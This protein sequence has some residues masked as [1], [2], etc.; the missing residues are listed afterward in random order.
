MVNHYEVLDLPGSGILAQETVEKA[1]VKKASAYASQS[2]ASMHYEERAHL[3]QLLSAFEV[4]G[5]G[6]DA[7]TM[8]LHYVSTGSI[9]GYVPVDDS[10]PYASTV[11]VANK[12]HLTNVKVDDSNVNDM[13]RLALTFQCYHM[14]G[15]TMKVD[16][17]EE[18][19]STQFQEFHNDT[20][21]LI[22]DSEKRALIAA[23]YK[24][25]NATLERAFWEQ[26][27][28]N[29][30]CAHRILTTNRAQYDKCLQRG[31]LQVS[32]PHF[33]PPWADM[34]T[35]LSTRDTLLQHLLKAKSKSSLTYRPFK[36]PTIKVVFK[37]AVP[38]EKPEKKR[39]KQDGKKRKKQDGKKRKKQDGK[40]DGKKRK[41]QDGKNDGKKRKKQDGK[42]RKKQDGK[43]DGKKRKKQDGKNDGKKHK[44][45]DGKNDGKKHKKQ[46]G[47]KHKKQDGKKRKKHKKQDGKERTAQHVS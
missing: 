29:A 32:L 27:L 3:D 20:M 19:L 22:C 10:N 21:K 18:T 43:N 8:Y 42:K 38:I 12:A 2:T 39:K 9:T 25:P 40:N 7:Q 46:D 1:F 47:K 44:K 26:R 23:K 15:T 6:T 37:A 5:A 16:V 24:M 13:I 14:L 41:K 28:R 34:M 17:S 11:G 30:E 4:L 36:L 33:T 45:Q 35:V 31:Y